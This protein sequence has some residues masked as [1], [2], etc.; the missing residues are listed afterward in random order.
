HVERMATAESRT[1]LFYEGI[2]G[3]VLP[4]LGVSTILAAGALARKESAQ[5]GTQISAD[6]Y[7]AT[8][9]I[10]VGVGGVALA[11]FLVNV[12]RGRDTDRDVGLVRDE[13]RTSRSEAPCEEHAAANV[14]VRLTDESGE[15]AGTVSDGAGVAKLSLID[16]GEGAL[17]R[18]DVRF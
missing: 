13:E 1:K 15:I 18:D 7:R 2:A 16:V 6:D 12:M 9:G 10:I 4:A 5:E 17:T 8:G 3:F 14:R 11:F